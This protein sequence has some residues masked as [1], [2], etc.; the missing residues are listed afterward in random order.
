MGRFLALSVPTR[1][2]THRGTCPVTPG[3]C[4]PFPC[5]IQERGEPLLFGVSLRRPR[6]PPSPPSQAGTFL[7]NGER[8]PTCGRRD[9]ER[10][11]VEPERMGVADDCSEL[12]RHGCGCGG[13]DLLSV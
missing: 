6:C 4:G 10:R 8:I 5:Q 1:E 7:L 12:H 13:V 11:G 2:T 9:H 3:P